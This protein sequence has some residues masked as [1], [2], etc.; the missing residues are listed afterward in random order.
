VPI[1]LYS[2]STFTGVLKG[3]GGGNLVL[4]SG[5]GNLYLGTGANGTST[6]GNFA[7]VMVTP[8]GYVGIGTTDPAPI[9]KPLPTASSPWPARSRLTT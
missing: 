4:T 1:Y 7:S 8:S 9:P 2:G 5:A 3:D 6:Y